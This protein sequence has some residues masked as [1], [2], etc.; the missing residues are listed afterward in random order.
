LT[1]I[2][3]I[4][5]TEIAEDYSE[6]YSTTFFNEEAWS[7]GD[8]D[9]GHRLLHSFTKLMYCKSLTSRIAF[10]ILST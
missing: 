4:N 1:F 2:A 7:I 10:S 8:T 6:R 9:A 3:S 5:I